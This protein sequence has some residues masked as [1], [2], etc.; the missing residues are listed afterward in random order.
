MSILTISR[1]P[2]SLGDEVAQMLS[3]RLGWD[4][5][6]RDSLFGLFFSDLEGSHEYR[7]LME[8]AKRFLAPDASGLPYKERVEQG[9]RTLAHD[10]SLVLI[11]FGSQALF[12]DDPDALH[13]RVVASQSVRVRRFRKQYHL[14]EA[15]AVRL[16]ETSDR[17]HRRFVSTVYGI[18][19]TDP[20]LYHLILNTD[21]LTV[22]ECADTLV[23]FVRSHEAL[24][25]MERETLTLE[26]VD[27]HLGDLPVFKN[28]AEEEFARILDMYQIEWRYEPRTFP[29]EWDSEGNVK[30]AFSPDFFLPKF[31]TYIELT[32]MNQKYVTMKN[33]KAKKVRE[34]YPGTNIKIMYKKDIQAL[35]ERF[36]TPREE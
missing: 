5:I 34:L 19:L 18:D 26:A 36:G 21:R 4:L 1:Q 12:A 29:V 22:G 14:P 13:V 28:K 32:T 11:G 30:M 35:A 33:R 15:E 7:M 27:D 10:K 2:G 16:L 31:N 25:R 8:S 6:R 20:S 23:S 9:L 24:R 3:Q 17:K